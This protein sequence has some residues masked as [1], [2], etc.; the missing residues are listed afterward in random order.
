MPPPPRKSLEEQVPV[1]L[2]PA[3]KVWLQ[4]QGI[5]ANFPNS[6]AQPRLA[7]QTII[8]RN[9]GTNFHSPGKIR[10]QKKFARNQS[11]PYPRPVVANLASNF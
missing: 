6:P 3:M 2:I 11:S 1:Y 4:E 10:T 8:R 5:Q 7:H 9:E